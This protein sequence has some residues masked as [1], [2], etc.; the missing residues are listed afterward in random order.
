MKKKKKHKWRG[1]RLSEELWRKSNEGGGDR[2][3]EMSAMRRKAKRDQNENRNEDNRAEILWKRGHFHEVGVE[4]K[5][6]KSEDNEDKGE[7]EKK[8]RKIRRKDNKDNENKVGDRDCK[9]NQNKTRTQIRKSKG[10][11]G[12]SRKKKNEERI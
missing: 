5:E 4:E 8:N 6:S 1:K 3:R 7:E 12:Y 11:D 2:R 9:G 10:D